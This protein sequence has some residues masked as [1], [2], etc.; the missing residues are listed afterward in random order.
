[1]THVAV[2]HLADHSIFRKQKSQTGKIFFGR[3]KDPL[4]A[5]ALSGWALKPRKENAKPKPDRDILIVPFSD[6]KK[7]VTFLLIY[8]FQNVKKHY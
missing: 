4:H 5:C 2:R 1:M 3:K 6:S 8:Y 7:N